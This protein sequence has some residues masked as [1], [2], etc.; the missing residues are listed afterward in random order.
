MGKK[1]KYLLYSIF[2]VL[3]ITFTGVVSVFSAFNS[4]AYTGFYFTYNTST[5]YFDPSNKELSD[6]TGISGDVDFGVDNYTT[7][8]GGYAT[9][10]YTFTPVDISN[11][12]YVQ[13][14]FYVSDKTNLS[15][16]ANN[17]QFEISSSGEMDINERN[18]NLVTYFSS[19]IS[20]TN[21]WY[22]LIFPISSM[23]KTG[24]EINLKAVNFVRIY[25]NVFDE[26]SGYTGFHGKIGNLTFLPNG[27]V[28]GG[29]YYLNFSTGM[30]GEKIVSY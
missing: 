5:I 16:M 8:N 19:K 28:T 14:D 20:K 7:Y 30:I 9:P 22:R 25:F 3:T 17:S 4:T 10:G 29:I 13:L 1:I 18:I 15:K 21:C 26:S 2:L 12:A 23:G 27:A 24:G 6:G 11:C